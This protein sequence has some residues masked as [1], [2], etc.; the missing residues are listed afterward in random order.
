MTMN[1]PVQRVALFGG[2][3]D[4]VHLGHLAIA[5]AAVA[6]AGLARV[7]F[8]PT[9]ISPHKSTGPAPAAAAARIEML[10]LATAGFPWAEVSDWELRQPAPSWSW[11]TARHFQQVLPGAELFWL[12]GAD[13]WQVIESWAKPE[14]LQELLTFLVFPRP[15]AAPPELLPGWRARVLAVEHP[16]SATAIRAALAAGRPGPGVPPGLPSAVADYIR[17]HHLYQRGASN[18]L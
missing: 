15:P 10:R 9:R 4:P 5:E 7:I 2:S 11:R 8:L 12:L 13:Q 3:F 17:Q 18:V 1:S 16:A 14:V 6:E